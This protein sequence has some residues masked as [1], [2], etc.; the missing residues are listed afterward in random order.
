MSGERP[1]ERP[2]ELPTGRA[3]RVVADPAGSVTR[4]AVA[5]SWSLGLVGLAVFVTLVATGAAMPPLAPT[6]LL[7]LVLGLCI[8]RVALYPSELAAS[9]ELAVLLCAVTAFRE[10]APVTGPLLLALLVGPL[11]RD[12][13][14][15]RS[16]V[17]MAYNSGDRALASLGAVGAFA[18][19]TTLLGSSTGALIAATAAA[20][21]AAT[22]LDSAATVG[23]VVCLGGNARAARRELLDIDALALPLAVIGGAVGF[24]ATGVGWWAAALPLGLLALVPELLQARARIP[25]RVARDAILAAEVV[26]ALVAVALVSEPPP[27]PTALVLTVLAV[28]VGLELVVDERAPVPPVL[29]IVVVVAAVAVGGGS[30]VFAGALVGAL[31][32]ATSWWRGGRTRR[33]LA[34][35]GVAVAAAAG[36]IAAAMS[37]VGGGPVTVWAVVAGSVVVFAAPVIGLARSAWRRERGHLLWAA[38]LLVAPTALGIVPALGVAARVALTAALVVVGAGLGAWCGAPPWRSRMLAPAGTRLRGHARAPGFLVLCGGAVVLAVVGMIESSPDTRR[39]GMW[40]AVALGVTATTMALW[41]TR[42]WRLA[43][44]ARA[45]QTAILGAAVVGWCSV[46]SLALSA[47]LDAAFV[48]SA[49]LALVIACTATSTVRVGDRVVDITG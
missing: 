8:G 36:M 48:G 42:Q 40:V 24:L 7:A 43:P 5:Y 21:I 22:A 26:V 19:V 31:A 30:A 14:R 1:T 37:S 20:A 32:T 44:R 45:R 6:L 23:L 9:A 46:A 15:S 27:W 13:W 33:R 11:D 39:I 3:V 35:I 41:A 10:S 18:A 47:Q 34:P 17:R 2:T 38:P 16:V 49:A 28:V 4:A 29:G 25:G 12:H